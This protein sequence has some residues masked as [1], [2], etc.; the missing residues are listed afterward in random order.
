MSRPVDRCAPLRHLASALGG[1]GFPGVA[2]IVIVLASGLTGGLRAQTPALDA[3]V[4]QARQARPELAQRRAELSAAEARAAESRLAF[5]P[6]VSLGTSYTLA[7]GGRVIAFPVGDLL[8]PAYGALNDITQT[9]AF[10]QIENVEEQFFPNNFYDARLRV[11]QPILDPTLRLQRELAA[12]GTRAAQAAIES[13]AL[14]LDYRVRQ[15]F[16]QR[17]QAA[18]AIQILAAADTLLD[19]ALRTT[20]SLIRN[21][22]GLPLARERLL[23]EQ[24]QLRA[25]RAGAAAQLANAT[26][27]LTFL[28]GAQA[29]VIDSLNAGPRQAPAGEP[30]GLER[31]E[32]R[33]LRA[34][35]AATDVELAI[36]DKFRAPRLGA[37]VDAGS[38]DFDFG[39]QPYVLAG[40]TLD[41]PLYDGGRVRERRARLRAERAASEASIEEAELGFALEAELARNRLA[42]AEATLAY[43]ARAVASAE[44][45]LRDAR[46]LYRSDAGTYLQ[47]LDARTQ[48]TRVRLERNVAYYDTWLRYVDL[49]RALGR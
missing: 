36:E 18:E 24:A 25:Q 4:A 41:V 5:R 26:A 20:R 31:P 46:L 33:Q 8:N 34:A 9:E 42:A 22:A 11:E 48:V 16:F 45:A 38:Q 29:T 3:L 15:A 43:Y 23:A 21:G 1:A 35:V 37:R 44:R 47:L 49:L 39:W 40:L 30:D 32:L 28:T 12:T 2:T 27:L 17:L 7:A 6:N 14:A 13:S 10:P 19:E